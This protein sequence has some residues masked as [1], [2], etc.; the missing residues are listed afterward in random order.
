MAIPNRT[1]GT[2]S[3]VE[4][5]EIAEILAAG[6]TRLSGLKSSAI[7]AESGESSVGFGPPPS[8]DAPTLSIE[9]DA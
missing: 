7:S 8:G 3:V 1:P 2:E 5:T 9:V 6:L 4:L